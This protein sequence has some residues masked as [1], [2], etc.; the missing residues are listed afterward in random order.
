[1]SAA[2]SKYASDKIKLTDVKGGMFTWMTL[3][4]H[5]DPD[6]FFNAC[7]DAKVGIITSAAFSTKGLTSGNAFRLSFSY[8][9]KEK[10]EEGARILGEVTKRFCD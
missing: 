3:P 1:M 6:A 5:V 4:D 8:P 10:I 2:L 9:T 7:M